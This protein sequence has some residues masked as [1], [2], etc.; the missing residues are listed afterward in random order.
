M[1]GINKA[2]IA[3]LKAFAKEVSE[4]GEPALKEKQLKALEDFGRVRLSKNFFM[5]DF[6]YSEVS[7]IH[8]IPNP[9]LPKSR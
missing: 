3:A 1:D 9:S 6:L 5:R 2:G 4:R 7:A 8:G